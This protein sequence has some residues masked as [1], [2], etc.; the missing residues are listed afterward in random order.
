MDGGSEE[1]P[2]E[3]RG[4]VVSESLS[5]PEPLN[6]VTTSIPPQ[7]PEGSITWTASEFVAHTKSIAWYFMVIISSVIIAAII[8]LLTK[9]VISSSVIVIAGFALSFYG[10]KRPREIEY[11]I[12]QDGVRIG[13]KQYGFDRFRSFSTV[14]QGTFSS[15][16]LFPLK[17]FALLTSAYYD[18]SDEEKI[19]DIISNYLPLEEKRR[20]LVDEL[21][22]KI[23]F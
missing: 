18:P 1:H 7:G 20:D 17:R 16:V 10:A 8:W 19:I 4:I 2:Q 22:W 11:R 15:L 3:D 5:S 23:R 6:P 14:H 12:D 21:M 13:N 9:D